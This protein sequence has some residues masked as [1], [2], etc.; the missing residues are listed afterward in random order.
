MKIT[1]IYAV[2]LFLACICFSEI[3][4]AQN[5]KFHKDTSF[6]AVRSIDF[7][8]DSILYIVSARKLLFFSL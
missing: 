2:L 6:T 1:N 8:K 3:S 7:D 4:Y 5:I